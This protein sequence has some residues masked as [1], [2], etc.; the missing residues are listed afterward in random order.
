MRFALISVLVALAQPALACTSLEGPIEICTD[1]SEWKVTDQAGRPLQFV[2]NDGS[3]AQ[4]WFIDPEFIMGGDTEAATPAEGHSFALAE[5]FEARFGNDY[6]LLRRYED[7][8]DWIL[9]HEWSGDSATPGLVVRRF[10]NTE[11][12][13][14]DIATWIGKDVAW[15]EHLKLHGSF[16]RLVGGKEDAE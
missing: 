4:I 5:S 12:G 7:D 15:E 6:E 14:V 9:I 8:G 13:L 3:G 1:G 11:A 10:R 16:E 2:H